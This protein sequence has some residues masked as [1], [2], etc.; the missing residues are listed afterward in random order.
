M[1]DAISRFW[2]KYL[3]KTA[4]YKVPEGSRQWYVRRVEAFLNAHSGRKLA[5]LLAQDLGVYLDGIYRNESIP[6]IKL[7]TSSNYPHLY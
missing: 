5:S 3:S 6:P 4:A 1:D 7:S 2:D